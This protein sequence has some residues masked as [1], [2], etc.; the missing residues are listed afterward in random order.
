MKKRL[1]AIT[2]LGIG[3]I[4]CIPVLHAAAV[5]SLSQSKYEQYCRAQLG[6]GPNQ[7]LNGALV[8]NLR[9]CI[10]V[11]K[12]EVQKAAEFQNEVLR[13]QPRSWRTAVIGEEV[14]KRSRRSIVDQK[15]AQE[16]VREEYYHAVSLEDRQADLL[17]HRAERRK[18][19][20]DAERSIIM[21]QREKIYKWR[22][23]L[24]ICRSYS[25]VERQQCIIERLG[26]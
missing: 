19:V 7:P 4:P 17:R 13:N 16:E 20:Q 1:L 5:A 12:K 2:I 10:N 22:T 23:A 9:R 25:G 24:N 14:L 26:E 8:Y 3:I 11:T 21:Q 6:Y 18:A 15:E